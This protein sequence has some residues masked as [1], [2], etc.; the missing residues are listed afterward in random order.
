MNTR[1]IAQA[2]RRHVATCSAVGT[3]LLSSALLV[4]CG[5]GGGVSTG[6]TGATVNNLSV[7][8]VTGKGSTIVNGVRFDDSGI[9]GSA[10]EDANDD[11]ANRAN[12]VSDDVKNGMEV[13]IE[14]GVVTCPTAGL[15]VA[16]CDV[17]PTAVAKK[18]SFGGNSLVGP[19]TSVSTAA[20]VTTLVIF[21]QT[22]VTTANTVVNLEGQTALAA[23]QI[24]E[25]HGTYDK[26]SNTTTATRIEFKAVD[27]AAF[28]ATA[29]SRYRLRGELTALDTT[30]SPRTATIGGQAVVFA[31]GVDLTSIS[32]TATP[33][34]RVRIVPGT[35]PL[36]VESIKSGVRKL[37]D[38]KGAEAE[39]EGNA[40]GVKVDG[41]DTVFTINGAVVRVTA[42]TSFLPATATL[43]D[44]VTGV[45]VEA[46]GSVNAAGE[47]VARKLK[48]K[49]AEDEH[50]LEAELHGTISGY[51]STTSATS[52]TFTLRGETI[53]VDATTLASTKKKA[54]TSFA[55]LDT[56]AAKAGQ[57][58]EVKGIRSADGTKINATFVKK[59]D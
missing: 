36:Q 6:G 45:R 52:R 54:I 38:H 10:I 53:V 25:V 35:S 19:I 55:D 1:K 24:V 30:A 13:E 22:I 12:H 49:K 57:I 8:T 50:G 37:D 33:L 56:A 43:A 44:L 2:T 31:A 20:G 51:D 39:L 27:A 11:S 17:T 28:A 59:D 41:A 15:T 32:L 5:G 40:D 58:F 18:I 14:H 23:D 16:T 46:E 48:F 7:G 3:L 4:A 29:S 26:A 42:T 21:G 9:E 34:V 47:L